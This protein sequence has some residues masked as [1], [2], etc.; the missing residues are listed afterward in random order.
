MAGTLGYTV[1]VE[2]TYQR[3]FNRRDLGD[4][5]AGC[6]W[7]IISARPAVRIIPGSVDLGEGILTVA[8]RESGIDGAGESV[9]V[10]GAAYADDDHDATFHTHEDGSYFSF[11]FPGAHLHGDSWSLAAFLSGG[12]PALARHEILYIGKA[13]GDG[14]RTA[15]QRTA[16][17]EKLQVIYED[18]HGQGMDIFL[19]PLRLLKST[20][21][22]D[23]HIDDLEPGINLA[24]Y[25]RV[26]GD[27][28]GPVPAISVDLIEHSLISHFAPEYNVNLRKWKAPR[29][30]SPMRNMRSAG[31]RLLS[32]HL[33]TSGGLARFSTTTQP[34]ARRSH[35]IFHDVPPAPRRPV[36]RGISATEISEWRLGARL[37]REAPE[38]FSELAEQRDLMFRTFGEEAPP[39]RKPE[40]VFLS[41][42]TGSQSAP[43][44]LAADLIESERRL[45]AS[46]VDERAREAT[47][48]IAPEYQGEPTY[49]AAT[50]SIAIGRHVEDDE[51]TQWVLHDPQGNVQS[52]YLVNEDVQITTSTLVVIKHQA[53]LSGRFVTYLCDPADRLH[54]P[55]AVEAPTY[56]GFATS[57]EATVAAVR[58]VSDL[59]TDRAAGQREPVPHGLMLLINDAETIVDS[60]SLASSISNIL[61]NGP[62]VGI[63][64]VAAFNSGDGFTLGVERW[65]GLGTVKNKMYGL[66]V[67]RSLPVWADALHRPSLET[68]PPGAD[69]TFSVFHDHERLYLALLAVVLQAADPARAK[70]E[71]D[72]FLN[73]NF[74]SHIVWRQEKHNPQ[75]FSGRLSSNF[76]QWCIQRVD[77]RWV[78]FHL[79]TDDSYD[80]AAPQHNALGWANSVMDARYRTAAY[81]WRQ[82][83]APDR[84]RAK[85]GDVGFAVVRRVGVQ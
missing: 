31:F 26:F 75:R 1:A 67:P 73:D 63:G 51:P 23:D 57:P 55:S 64:L 2:H 25:K 65:H 78:L 49:D 34:E 77:S 14:S 5:L 61:A 11:Q 12:G 58:K 54:L 8:F 60:P 36:P 84:A 42:R 66:E 80:A 44:P 9:S 13:Y 29:Q 24:E 85:A 21:S 18:F 50:G 30:T 46:I 3:R 10:H 79:V 56:T 43:A 74:K 20:W 69:L 7:Y 47:E 4:A 83:P 70:A 53:E 76:T 6:H 35:F 33:D 32:V 16:Q 19:T 40:S 62:R 39:A 41:D 72:A 37:I 22:T 52:G 71:S 48:A 17:H 38:M 27:D 28:M 45:R 82:G 15:E 68:F 59:V 81:K